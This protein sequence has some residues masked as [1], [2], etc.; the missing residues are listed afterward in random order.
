[1]VAISEATDHGSSAAL[2][3]VLREAQL[4]NVTIYT[5]GLST[6][7]AQL[8]AQPEDKRPVSQT[9]TPPGTFG[10]PPVPGS[11][12]TPSNPGIGTDQGGDLLALGIWAVTH[13]VNTVKSNPLEVATVAT[14]G[15]H[16]PTFRD[17]SIEQA[18]DRVGGEL[19]AEYTLTYHP[20]G[21]AATGFHAIRIEVDKKELKVRT[22][23]GY[24][25]PPPEGQETPA[26]G[27]THKF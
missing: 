17:R 21:V 24:Y 26:P 11:V 2:G 25:L 27:E 23:P 1:V 22:R 8:R 16:V 20:T 10:T 4:N 14:G 9:A 6:T 19:H 18:I 13:A 3:E 12:Q 7:A 15:E 5:I